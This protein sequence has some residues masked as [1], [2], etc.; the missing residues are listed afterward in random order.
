MG[1]S[2]DKNFRIA[3]NLRGRLW[4]AL[5]RSIKSTYDKYGIDYKEIVQHLKKT[6]PKDYKINP[7]K[8]EVDHIKPLSSFNLTKDSEV[9]KAQS[10]ENV[11]WIIV[12]EHIAKDSPLIEKI[13]KIKI[14]LN[15]KEEING[16]RRTRTTIATNATNASTASA[17][18]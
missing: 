1:F 7:K 3:A 17:I 16:N 9:R 2:L 11:Q 8:Y 14:K 12:K 5:H 10:K 13:K 6:R 4:V 18:K 15:T